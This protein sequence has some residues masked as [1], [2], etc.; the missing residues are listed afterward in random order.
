[1]MVGPQKSGLLHG[2]SIF[3]ATDPIET[4]CNNDTQEISP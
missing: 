3:P 1:M 4:M 2:G